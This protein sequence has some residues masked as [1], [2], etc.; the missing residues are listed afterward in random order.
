MNEEKLSK[1]NIVI[2]RQNHGF[3]VRMPLQQFLFRKKLQEHN[4]RVSQNG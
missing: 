2:L 4:K 1:G 3:V